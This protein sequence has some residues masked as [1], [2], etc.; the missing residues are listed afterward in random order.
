MNTKY[1]LAIKECNYLTR[2]RLKKAL[3]FKRPFDF[4]YKYNDAGDQL[5]TKDYTVQFSNFSDEIT[6]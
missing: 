3:S 5:A 2:L 4:N 1:E 6:K